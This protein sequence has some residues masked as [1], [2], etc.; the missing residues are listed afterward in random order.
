MVQHD[1]ICRT[2]GKKKPMS[3]FGPHGGH[4][5]GRKRSC[6]KCLNAIRAAQQKAE[7]E[8]RR[9]CKAAGDGFD[10]ESDYRWLPDEARILIEM[11][12]AAVMAARRVAV[13]LRRG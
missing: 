9:K 6:R 12:R 13:V 5:G 4:S 3:A 8:Y 2:C 11:V 10:T 1:G 7:I